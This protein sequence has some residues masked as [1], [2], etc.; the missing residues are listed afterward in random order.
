MG[1]NTSVAFYNFAQWL[2]ET[3]H[4]LTCFLK[5]LFKETD[6]TTTQTA[7]VA[8]KNQESFYQALYVYLGMSPGTMTMKIMCPRFEH[9]IS[10]S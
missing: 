10:L 5:L 7:L 1:A 4:E 2:Y 8:L 6:Q 3:H 9:S